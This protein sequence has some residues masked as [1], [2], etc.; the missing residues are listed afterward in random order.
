M[1]NEECCETGKCCGFKDAE[2]TG[3]PALTADDI[4]SLIKEEHYTRVG[5]QTTICTLTLIN[6]FEVI[7]KAGCTDPARYDLKIGSQFAKADAVDKLWE[8][9]GY[10]RQR[11]HFLDNKGD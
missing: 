9:E 1:E 6:G 7:G 11:I 8:L 3:V 5:A 4:L 10:A 2:A